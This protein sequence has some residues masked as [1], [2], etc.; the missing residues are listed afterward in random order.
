[1]IKA[2]DILSITR[3]IVCDTKLTQVTR[4]NG[5]YFL[6]K[7]GVVVYVG[8]SNNILTRVSTH[9][10]FEFDSFN[11]F[12]VSSKK[13]L[14]NLEAYFIAKFKPAYNQVM[15]RNTVGL[16]NQHKMTSIKIPKKVTEKLV[17]EY[18]K[19]FCGS[20]SDEER[21][22]VDYDETHVKTTETEYLVKDLCIKVND[23]TKRMILAEEKNIN[24]EKSLVDKTKMIE[25]LSSQLITGSK[26]KTIEL[27]PQSIN[28]VFGI[29]I[30]GYIDEPFFLVKTNLPRKIVSELRKGV[31]PSAS[32]TLKGLINEIIEKG[33]GDKLNLKFIEEDTGHFERLMFDMYDTTLN[34]HLNKHKCYSEKRESIINGIKNK[35]GI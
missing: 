4:V 7:D 19:D 23:L 11:Y 35:L 14:D 8:Q 6:I 17:K 20:D 15:Q 5:I 31:P 9:S 12:E 30:D 22:D 32:V 10:T 29:V 25:G 1:M 33:F 21:T 16:T 13:R 26:N 27:W 24:L 18:G 2:K 28:G 3:E 34:K